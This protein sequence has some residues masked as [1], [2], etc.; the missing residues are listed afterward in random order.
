[1]ALG[2]Q[3]NVTTSWRKQK[4]FP[5]SDGFEAYLQLEGPQ[6]GKRN[7]SDTGSTANS[8]K[9]NGKKHKLRYIEE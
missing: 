7:R 4:N 1:M 5:D 3:E 2:I 9:H 6:V 8:D